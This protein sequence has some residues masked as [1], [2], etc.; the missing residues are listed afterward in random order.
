MLLATATGLSALMLA[1][2]ARAQT[3]NVGEV[4]GVVVTAPGYVP[5]TNVSATKVSIPL[6]ETPQSITVITRDQ[7]NV[8]NLQNLQ[9]AVRYTSGIIGENFGPDERYDWLTLRGFSPVAFIDGLQAPVGSV[10]NV[11]LDLWGAESLEILKG[12]SG[13]LY[14]QSPP[15][16]IVNYTSRRPQADFH[17]ELQGQYG[18]F[19]NYQIAGDITGSLTGDGAVMGRLTALWRDHDTQVN[20]AHATRVYIAPALIWRPN[21]ETQITL[22]GYY[23]HDNAT[24]GDG[25]FLPAIGTLLPNPNGQIAVD[26]NAGEPG[27]NLF[28]RDQY[29]VGYEAIHHF[30]SNVAFIQS[31]RYSFQDAS[32]NSVYGSGLEA[33]L[34]TLNRS[35]FIFP[36]NI[37]SF[38]V[39]SRV[40]I[41]GDTGD[42]RHTVLVGIDYRDV[43][44]HTAFGFGSAPSIDLFNPVYGQP[45]P[46]PFFVSPDYIRSNAEQI[47]LYAQDSLRFDRFRLTLSGRGDWLSGPVSD[48]AF[49]YRA[50]LNYIFDSGIAPYVAYATTFQPTAGADFNGN[51]FVP[52]EGRQIEAGVKYEPTGLPRDVR[53]FASAAVYD[54]TQDHVL[55]NDPSHLFFSVQTGEVR[56]R[57][58]E[59]EGV[60]RLRERLT[61]NGSYS[62]TDSEVTRSNGGDLGKQLPAV[63]RHKAALLVDYTLQT[64]R[65]AGLG[66]GVGVRY[67]GSLYGDAANTLRSDPETLADLI[68]HYDYRNWRFAM[69]ANNVT[70][71]VYVQRCS[72]LN[73]CFYSQR[74][75]VSVT[76]GR[77]W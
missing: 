39:D 14:G 4:E 7:I 26:F 20:G 34:R 76:I 75:N 17:A 21:D 66:V 1:G 24:G 41:T 54:L 38:A 19:D 51:A 12:P 67:I 58:L 45:I 72:A 68:V 63:P 48:N 25:G 49:T 35:N 53:L 55:T 56:V 33:D 70:D 59:L 71:E 23:Q 69:N 10:G 40:E 44:N 22:L 28:R 6:V 31:L 64:G 46:P 18:S 30:N 36:E 50:G 57:G 42:V 2:T 43:R 13:V 77:R 65:F 11:G 61:I 73:S 15:G 5:T 29:G 47:G 74:R 8:L 27:Y 9:Q 3:S 62:Y 16:G 32:F 52:S 37:R 60:A